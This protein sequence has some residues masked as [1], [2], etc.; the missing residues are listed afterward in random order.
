MAEKRVDSRK[1]ETN[2]PQYY[3]MRCEYGTSLMT[4]WKGGG[5]GDLYLCGDHSEVLRREVA[6][7]T[8]ESQFPA[9]QAIAHNFNVPV[10]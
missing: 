6:P 2:L 3:V 4:L 8:A 7:S 1:R 10:E 9:T 5:A